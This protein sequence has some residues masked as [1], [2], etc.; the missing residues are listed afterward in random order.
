MS[1][2]CPGCGS[3]LVRQV[4]AAAPQADGTVQ[5]CRNPRCAL[6]SRCEVCRQ[7]LEPITE[8]VPCARARCV[9]ETCRRFGREVDDDW[10][11][12]YAA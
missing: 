1:N 6:R 4:D 10:L 8:P 3:R 5:W 12:R 9:T 11:D 7:P 2:A